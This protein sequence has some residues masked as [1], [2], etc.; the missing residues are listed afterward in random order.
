MA[1]WRILFFYFLIYSFLGWV[2][3]GIFNLFTQGHFIKPNFL[4]L[5]LKPMYGIASVLLV[6]LKDQLPLVLFLLSCFIIPSLVEYLTAFL[7]FH[8]F[9][10]K[11]WDY[12]QCPYNLSGYVCL[13]FSIYWVILSLALVYLIHPLIVVIYQKISWFWF[14]FFPIMLLTFIID[15]YLSIKNK[16]PS[17]LYTKK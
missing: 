17:H 4:I 11:Y 1:L 7:L 13:R 16:I 3:E 2:T 9:E 15:T 6:L 5:P 12:S 14:Y 8:T 10:L